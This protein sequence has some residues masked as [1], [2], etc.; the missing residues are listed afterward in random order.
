M[1]IRAHN[2]RPRGKVSKKKNVKVKIEEKQSTS[3]LSL[4]AALCLTL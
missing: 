4:I 1:Q 3:D 2:G